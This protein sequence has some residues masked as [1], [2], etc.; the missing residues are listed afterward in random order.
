MFFPQQ[1]TRK[2]AERSPTPPRPP[3]VRP[4]HN[5][6]LDA[7]GNS[8]HPDWESKVSSSGGDIYYKN[9]KTNK[10]TWEIPEPVPSPPPPPVERATTPP[11]KLAVH[12]DRLKLIPSSALPAGEWRPCLSVVI[13]SVW[14]ELCIT[15]KDSGH[16]NSTSER[17]GEHRPPFCDLVNSR[18]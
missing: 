7:N 4:P 13:Q 9:L 15:G 10:T 6:R 3:P 1:D 8:L 14:S 16:V 18:A 2:N 12:P 5:P 17:Q 11:R